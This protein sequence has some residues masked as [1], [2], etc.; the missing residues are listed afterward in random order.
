MSI[1]TT[2]IDLTAEGTAYFPRK[3]EGRS[4]PLMYF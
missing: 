4:L 1:I 3:L 2:L